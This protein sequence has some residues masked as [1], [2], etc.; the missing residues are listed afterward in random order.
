MSDLKISTPLAL[1]LSIQFRGSGS[2]KQCSWRTKRLVVLLH[3]LHADRRELYFLVSAET[4]DVHAFERC[5]DLW[6]DCL[7]YLREGLEQG[8][9]ILL[10]DAG[11][12]VGH[13]DDN[14]PV[15]H[16]QPDVHAA[17]GGELYGIPYCVEHCKWGET[18]RA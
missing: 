1:P 10:R 8:G 3:A 16:P 2:L 9:K 18:S 7:P 13:G 6:A 11:P 12:R 4:V 5:N 17:G 14:A 15:F